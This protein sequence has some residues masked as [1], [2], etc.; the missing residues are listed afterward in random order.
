MK[1]QFVL[2]GTGA[3][4]LVLT[5]ENDGEKQI[6]AAIAGKDGDGVSCQFWPKW[7]S[8]RNPVYRKVESASIQF[9]K[10]D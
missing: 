9:T 4:E 5:P 2:H 10:E 6:L 3:K 1:F 7:S 8:D